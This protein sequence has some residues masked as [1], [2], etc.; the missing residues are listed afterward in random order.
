MTNR[1]K[2]R[3]FTAWANMRMSVY[4]QS[5]NNIVSDLTKG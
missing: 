5:T 4:D 3:G 2:I 1:A